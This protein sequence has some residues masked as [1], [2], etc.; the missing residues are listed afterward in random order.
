MVKKT[1]ILV[2]EDVDVNMDA[3]MGKDGPS[4]GELIVDHYYSP[5]EWA[6]LLYTD[7]GKVIQIRESKKQNIDALSVITTPVVLQEASQISSITRAIPHN[8]GDQ[9]G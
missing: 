8:A 5:E 6:T 4:C 9:F 2:L 7:K 1:F 3:V